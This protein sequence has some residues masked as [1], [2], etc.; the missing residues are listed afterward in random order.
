M[1]KNNNM[2]KKE[3]ILKTVEK[4]TYWWQFSFLQKA[5]LVQIIQAIMWIKVVFRG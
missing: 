2:K 4:P 1:K 5:I 3:N